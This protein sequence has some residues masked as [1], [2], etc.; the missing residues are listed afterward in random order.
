M[1]KSSAK[2]LLV[3]AAIAGLSAGTVT[4]VSGCSSDDK[5]CDKASCKA[6]SSCKAA[7]ASCS[8]KASCKA[9]DAPAK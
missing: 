7:A 1:K 8:A 5:S 2:S 6:K 3:A 4:M 9:A